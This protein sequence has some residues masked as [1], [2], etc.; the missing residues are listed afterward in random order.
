MTDLIPAPPV[1]PS[2]LDSSP[3]SPR[4]NAATKFLIALVAVVLVGFLFS[5]FQTMLGPLAMALVLAYVLNPVV[6][7]VIARAQLSWAMTV[8]LVFL[9][10]VVGLLGLLT[11][12]GIAI[13][14]QAVGLYRSVV[15][16]ADDLP[17][18]VEDLLA[19]P[20]SLGLF[21]VDLSKPILLGPFR[22]DLN[23]ADLKPLYDQ[24]LEVIRPLLSETG[25]F[26]GSLASGTAEVLG[27]TLFIIIISYYLLHDL[28]KVLPSI[29]RTVPA[30]YAPDVHRLAAEL[31]PI[32]N[33]FLRGQITVAFILGLTDGIL[34]GLLGVSYAPI[35]GL[36]VGISTFIPLVGPAVTF[37]VIALVALFQPGNW[38]GLGPVY[39]LVVIS[40]I[41]FVV[42]QIYD[43]VLYPRILGHSLEL[44]PII[45]LVGAIM[46]ANLA[47][48][49]G[50]LLSAPV[51]A[52]LRLFG[53]YV[54][55]K[56][57]DLDPFPSDPDPPSPPP[58]FKWPPVWLQKFLPRREVKI[59][60]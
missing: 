3:Q 13:E 39:Y 36:L 58:P 29:E 31:G 59:K 49:V 41:Y 4:W 1:S 35:L 11:A 47:G 37:V 60:N 38:L 40:I 7:W 50:L 43:N 19:K 22:L 26:L 34:L 16:I 33:A 46:A 12:A 10:L 18:R 21:T 51:I 32:W 14:Q 27:W 28:S 6:E 55:R 20:L 54:Y 24:L 45:I 57:F 48:I 56:L 8:N 52:S 15:E 2:P 23:T 17:T 44:H 9:V 42:Q 25:T 5:R 30:G 53:G